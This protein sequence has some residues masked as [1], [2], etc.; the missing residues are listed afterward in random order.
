MQDFRALLPKFE[1]FLLNRQLSFEAIIIG[2]AAMQLLGLTD[3]VT[4][5]CDVLSPKITFELKEASVEFAKEHGLSDNWLNNG[6]ETLI[7]DL[8]SDWQKNIVLLYEGKNLKL[9]TLSRLDFIRSKL[10]AYL[11][12]GIDLQDLTKLMPTK[13]E[14]DQLR[15]WLKERDGNPDWPEYVEIR[16][17]ELL[18]ELYGNS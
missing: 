5:D 16:L 12:R 11:D 7:R 4:K 14:I 17:S 9:F 3:R 1:L 15:D 6:P 13:S 10:F 18:E 2:G 8:P